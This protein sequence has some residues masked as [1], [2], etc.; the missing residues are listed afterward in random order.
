MAAQ[1]LQPSPLICL[2]V[3]NAIFNGNIVIGTAGKG[4]DFSAQTGT[5]TADYYL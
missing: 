1:P 2:K 4:I 5:A 3:R